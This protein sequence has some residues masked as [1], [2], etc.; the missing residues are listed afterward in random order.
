[1]KHTK[2]S[3]ITE[4]PKHNLSLA[5]LLPAYP[6]FYSIHLLITNFNYKTLFQDSLP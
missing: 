6:P 2:S 4:N 1:M 3:W 5:G